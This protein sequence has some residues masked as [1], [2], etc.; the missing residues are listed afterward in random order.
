LIGIEK[1]MY[2]MINADAEKREI[3]ISPFADPK[4]KLAKF[5]IQMSDVPGSLAKIA[6]ILAD[7]GIDLLASESR[8]IKRGE[9]AEWHVI[10]DISKRTCEIEEL[11]DKLI[12]EGGARSVEFEEFPV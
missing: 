6:K 11:K 2:V 12:E 5:R 1:G 10:A 3:L 8:T 4:A 7:A 9:L